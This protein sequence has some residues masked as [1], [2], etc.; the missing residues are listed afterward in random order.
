VFPRRFFIV[1][2][3]LV[4]NRLTRAQAVID[5]QYSLG[6][7][8]G[9]LI[10]Q[11][12]L[13]SPPLP[14]LETNERHKIHIQSAYLSGDISALYYFRASD[15]SM[16]PVLGYQ[17]KSQAYSGALA[18]ASPSIGRF[19]LFTFGLYTRGAANL[20]L[21]GGAKFENSELVST[22]GALGTNYVLFGA[23]DSPFKVGLFGGVFVSKVDSSYDYVASSGS[24]SRFPVT[25]DFVDYGPFAGV[26]AELRVWKLSARS[27]VMYAWDI[28]KDAVDLY[29]N[30]YKQSSSLV[31]LNSSFGAIGASV[32]FYRFS[33][34]VYSRIW[35]KIDQ[36]DIKFKKYQVGYTFPL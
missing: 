4:A 1:L 31:K 17:G 25:A 32:G 5:D 6:S 27:F 24:V 9:A 26:Q 3:L 36:F 23:G 20:E 22:V 16:A 11:Q 7:R 33:I 2:I 12:K 8:F 28:T 19:S 30:G 21:F 35:G 14:S 18:Y 13:A 10:G 15:G 29:V 34:S